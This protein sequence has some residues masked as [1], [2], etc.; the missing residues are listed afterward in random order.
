MFLERGLRLQ[1]RKETEL[2]AVDTGRFI[3]AVLENSVKGI[4]SCKDEQ[5]F[6]ALAEKEGQRLLQEPQFALEEGNASN[7][8]LKKTLLEES[9]KASAIVY[10]QIKGSQFDKV[11][12]EQ[13]VRTPTVRGKVD[14]VDMS[15]DYLRIIDYKTESID[16]TPVSYYVGKKLQMQLYMSA[17]QGDKKPMGIFYFP[18]QRDFKKEGTSYKL[19]GFINGD[20]D[21]LR[22]GDVAITEEKKSEYFDAQLGNNR[23]ESVMSGQ[24]FQDFLAYAPLVAKK[25]REEIAEGD[26]TPNPYDGAC[27]YC[28]MSGVCGYNHTSGGC[29][30][31]TGVSVQTIVDAVRKEKEV[32]TDAEI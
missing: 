6:C 9:V 29:R 24:D 7:A 11:L 3:H 26:F 18:T 12:V 8:Y 19:K 32:D 25:A 23:S 17:L 30:K 27:S 1:E 31:E 22:S 10:R 21:S 5:A 2:L 28:K 20:E 13:D 14:R 16:V 4:D 15:E